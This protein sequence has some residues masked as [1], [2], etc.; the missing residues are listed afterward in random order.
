MWHADDP[1]SQDDVTRR[2]AIMFD[3]G[4]VDMLVSISTNL[5]QFSLQ[6]SHQHIFLDP[7]EGHVRQLCAS[8]FQ[9]LRLLTKNNSIIALY[10]SESILNLIKPLE[11]LAKAHESSNADLTHMYLQDLMLLIIEIFHDSPAA[12][13]N[14]QAAHLEALVKLFTNCTAPTWHSAL[15]H[16]ISMMCIYKARDSSALSNSEGSDLLQSA[17]MGGASNDRRSADH[18]GVPNN[19]KQIMMLLNTTP[20]DNTLLD[21]HV[22]IDHF[23]STKI[24]ESN[25]DEMLI[26]FKGGGV[27]DWRPLHE[28]L[29]VN[30]NQQLFD[31]F[32]MFLKNSTIGRNDGTAMARQIFT[33]HQ[34]MDFD[35]AVHIL[36]SQL[37]PSRSRAVAAAFLVHAF[38]DQMP[39]QD[40]SAAIRF[41]DWSELSAPL[42]NS[43]DSSPSNTKRFAMLQ[44]FALFHFESNA[45]QG[46]SF[47]DDC[48]MKES[49]KLTYFLVRY[50]FYSQSIKSALD[51]ASAAQLDP[52]IP[53]AAKFAFDYMQVFYIIYSP[54]FGGE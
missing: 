10:L 32:M 40:C 53:S 2:Q 45:T 9:V 36:F 3:M 17:L 29:T 24:S 37:C 15:L 50:G 21:G 41:Q 34:L 16:L 51:Q 23:P 43:F 44:A 11:N 7:E 52:T 35:K 39:Q 42:A 8:C 5:E 19:Q 48:L 49:L 54:H 6:L 27:P 25:H 30:E 20:M 4:L 46:L 18:L 22:I 47:H 13:S 31:N 38:I 28:A 12:L 14:L 1:S 26:L 33:N